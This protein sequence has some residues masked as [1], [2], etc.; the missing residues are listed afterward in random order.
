MFVEL[1]DNE[2]VKDYL[3]DGQI[4]VV[5][6]ATKTCP[7]CNMLKP[8]F[9]KLGK[10]DDMDNVVF[11]AADANTHPESREF[12]VSSV[13]A[14]FFFNGQEVLGQNVGFVPEKPLYDFVKKLEAGEMPN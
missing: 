4:G 13:P 2:S 1:K 11:I 7:P 10:S 5:K 6:F 3:K 14:L 12:G 9:E 8:I